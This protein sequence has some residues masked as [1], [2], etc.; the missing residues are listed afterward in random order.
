MITESDYYN[1]SMLPVSSKKSLKYLCS[2]AP[3][4]SMSCWKPT[5]GLSLISHSNNSSHLGS[6]TPDRK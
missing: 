1:S 6:S 3:C 4:S 5:G 2:L